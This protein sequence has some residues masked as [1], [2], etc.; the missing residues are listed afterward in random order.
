MKTLV[1]QWVSP[2]KKYG[3]L[4]RQFFRVW[5]LSGNRDDREGKKHTKTC[6]R[7]YYS[8]FRD[9]FMMDRKAIKYKEMLLHCNVASLSARGVR[10]FFSDESLYGDP[11][12]TT[13][14]HC[15]FIT[16]KGCK[17]LWKIHAKGTPFHPT[18]FE[19]EYV[20]VI[21]TVRYLCPI[22]NSFLKLHCCL[23]ETVRASFRF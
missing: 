15:N 10:Q 19:E 4:A 8:V 23:Y 2:A 5:A 3:F 12:M 22:G 21:K 13:K 20:L 16:F 9:F 1:C 6:S 7:C 11:M 17:N 14:A 18:F